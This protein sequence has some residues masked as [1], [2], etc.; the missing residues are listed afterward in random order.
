MPSPSSL[1]AAILFG[2]IGMGAFVHGKRNGLAMPAL[3]GVALMV[4]PY[5]VSETWLVFSIG[6]LLCYMLYL[7]R[8]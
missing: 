7:F 1:F 3:I 6:A 5:F 2:A 4:Y 8:N